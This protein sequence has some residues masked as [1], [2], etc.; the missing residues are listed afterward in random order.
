MTQTLGA[1]IE[2][3][4]FSGYKV[5]SA[6]WQLD[7]NAIETLLYDRDYGDWQRDGEHC[8]A[9][10]D[11]EAFTAVEINTW[12]CTDQYVGLEILCLN[13]TPVALSWQTG[14]KSDRRV[15]LLTPATRD[16]FIEAWERHRP[17]DGESKA[18]VSAASLAL[19]IAGPGEKPFD[20][21]HSS[22]VHSLRLSVRGLLDW[23]ASLEPQGGIASITDTATLIG[24]RDAARADIAN[25]RR[26]RDSFDHI[27]EDKK[28]EN[29]ELLASHKADCEARIAEV[30][31]HLLTPILHRLAQLGVEDSEST[32]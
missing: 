28:R 21:D 26:S 16:L 8:S 10:Y 3:G 2:S 6:T 24:A 29:A 5:E 27:D 4:D 20:I 9:F 32:A 1:L 18:F 11:K 31:A 13:G 19:P 7:A 23:I 25:M 15:A 17:A 30:D 12:L 14:R 22:P